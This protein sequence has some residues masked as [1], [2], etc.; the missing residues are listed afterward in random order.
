[1]LT[2]QVVEW[3]DAKF[4]GLNVEKKTAYIKAAGIGVIEGLMDSA[5]I[6]GAASIAGMAVK[7]VKTTIKK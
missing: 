5:L 4:E 7:V 6:I 2:K 3:C 1:M